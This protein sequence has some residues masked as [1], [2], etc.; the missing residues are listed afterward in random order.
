MRTNLDFTQHGI[1]DIY[2]PRNTVK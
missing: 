2:K 1:R